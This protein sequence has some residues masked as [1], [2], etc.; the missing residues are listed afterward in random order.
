MSMGHNSRSKI[1]GEMKG[2]NGRGGQGSER[3]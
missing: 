2:N 3:G 1:V